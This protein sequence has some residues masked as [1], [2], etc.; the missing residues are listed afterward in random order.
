M[1]DPAPLHVAVGVIRNPDGRILLTQRAKNVHQGGLWEFPGGKLEPNESPEQALYRELHEEVGIEVHHARPLLKIKHRYPE[2]AVLLDVWQ[3][4]GYSGTP[5]AREGQAMAWA[6]PDELSDYRFPAANYPII[7]AVRLPDR[8]A[9]L[10]GVNCSSISD[11][12]EL[13][14]KQGISL[15]Q[16]RCKSARTSEISQLHHQVAAFCKSNA[17]T[18]LGNSDHNFE[19]H[20]IDGIHLTARRL[21]T[22]NHRP[23]GFDWVA[24]SCHNIGELEHA[25]RIGVDFAVLAPVMP[26]PT[27]PDAPALGWSAVSSLVAEINIPVFAMGGL[28][29]TDLQ[30]AIAA[31]CQGMAGISAFLTADKFTQKPDRSY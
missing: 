21:V 17:I 15:L 22:L 24:A 26:T 19:A 8:Y 13:L 4:V 10:E 18:L 12:L 2:L 14:K 25:Q 23:R 7:A 30:R 16:F 11:K 1:L 27:H 9:I 3:V 20:D 28:K 6:K 5:Y 29:A 31:G